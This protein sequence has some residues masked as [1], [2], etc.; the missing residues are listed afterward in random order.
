MIRD[1]DLQRIDARLTHRLDQLDA[2]WRR[3]FDK[4]ETDMRRADYK[5]DE[6]KKDIGSVRST[7]QDYMLIVCGPGLLAV[8]VWMSVWMTVLHGL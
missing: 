3:R 1:L 4:I 8:I 6:L 7:S 2:E 5:L